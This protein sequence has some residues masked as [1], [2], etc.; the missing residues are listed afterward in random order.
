VKLFGAIAL[1]LFAVFVALH[2]TGRGLH[3]HGHHPEPVGS[4]VP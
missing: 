3:R 1:T 4:G 2:L